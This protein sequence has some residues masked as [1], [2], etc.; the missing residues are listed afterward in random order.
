LRSSAR[1]KLEETAF[2]LFDRSSDKRCHHFSFVL[3][4]N[5]IIAIG[6]NNRKTHPVNLKNKKFSIYSG[7]DFSTEKY[8][9]SEYN[10]IL[11]LKR[12]TNIDTKKCQLVNLRINRNEEIDY[13]KP[14]S[15]CRNLLNYFE[16]KSVEF[17]D[18]KGE[19]IRM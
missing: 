14:C 6:Q 13:A 3:Y 18:K 15:S 17:T 16:F 10:A 8:T 12:L 11:K 19:Y 5:R 4:K 9:C 7:L 1:K 2:S